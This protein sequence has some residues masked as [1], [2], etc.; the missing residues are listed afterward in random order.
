[1]RAAEAAPA[2]VA[3]DELDSLFSAF[4]SHGRVVLAVSGG[5]DSIAMMRL[6]ADWARS[7]HPGLL[8]SV[9]TVENSVRSRS[10]YGGTAPQNVRKMAR[11]WLKRLEKESGK[12]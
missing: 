3:D 7:N 5:A 10:S 12:G 4:P 2:A 1:M 11:A 8:L 9:L 6:A